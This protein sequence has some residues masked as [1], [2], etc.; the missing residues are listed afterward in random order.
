MQ[1]IPGFD[2]GEQESSPHG[3]IALQGSALLSATRTANWHNRQ[4]QKRLQLSRRSANSRNDAG[5]LDLAR[6]RSLV[7]FGDLNC[8]LEH[9]SLRSLATLEVGFV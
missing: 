3:A 1:R 8:G 7:G 4:V 5:A 6:S 9:S 2:V